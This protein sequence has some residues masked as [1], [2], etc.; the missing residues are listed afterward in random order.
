M[1]TFSPK[2]RVFLAIKAIDFRKGI[3]GIAKLCQAQYELNPMSGHYFVFRNKRKTDTKILYYD[4]Q[5]FCLVQ[6]RLSS[7]R[8]THWPAMASDLV[9]LT[10]TQMQVL[11][12]NG[13]PQATTE[14]EAWQPIIE[15]VDTLTDDE[16]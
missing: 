13:D 2:H 3:R 10:A 6:K 4:S 9:T 5:G 8:F 15:P 1:I 16:T 14:A 11:L 12:N 7:G